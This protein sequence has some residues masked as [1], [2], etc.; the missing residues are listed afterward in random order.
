MNYPTMKVSELRKLVRKQRLASGLA[1]AGARKDVLLQALALGKWPLEVQGGVKDDGD[2]VSAYL[3]SM[4]LAKA[5]DKS[6]RFYLL[7][8][9]IVSALAGIKGGGHD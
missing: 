4:E 9:R 6:E 1:V 5:G 3:E 7:Q 2:L 8:G